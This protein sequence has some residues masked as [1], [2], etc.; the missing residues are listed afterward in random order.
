M[1]NSATVGIASTP[2]IDPINR[3]LDL[4]AYTL[5]GSVP[6]YTLHALN[7][8][9]LT[10]KIGPVTVATS[11][12]LSNGDPVNFNAQYQ[13]QRPALLNANGAIY[14]GFGAF[15]DFKLGAPRGWLLG[16]NANTL[17]PFTVNRLND[18][19]PSSP[20]GY[21]LSSIW[22]SGAGP[23]AD[24]YG[25]LYFS[26]GNSDFSGTTYDPVKNISNTVAK[27]SVD[28]TQ[29][30]SKFTPSNVAML[31]QED[32]DFGSGGV[33]LVPNRSGPVPRLAVAGGKDG[34]MGLLNR[35]VLG[36][37]LD[38][39]QIGSCWCAP[40]YFTGPDGIGR[41]VS[42]GSSGVGDNP[43][44]AAAI[45][46]WKLQT[47][48]A[49][50][51]VL[52]GAAAAV[53]SGQDGGTFT[54]VSSNGTQ[55]GTGIIWTVGRPVAAALNKTAVILYA[56]TATPNSGILVPLFAGVSGYW[57]YTGGD[58]NIVPVV[59]NGKVLVAA[60]RTL[61]IFGLHPVAAAPNSL[62]VI[63]SMQ[64]AG[65]SAPG[66][67]EVPHEITGT[68][69]EIKGSAISI[70][71]RS[72]ETVMIDATKA[73]QEQRSAIL[74]I[75]KAFSVQGTYDANGKLLATI[76]VRAKPSAGACPP[77]R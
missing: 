76:I 69:L 74:V 65:L 5:V 29:L 43:Y 22:M 53:V 35:D 46:V 57:P 40:S 72:D 42:S 52:E 45:A 34:N 44:N 60:W 75:G 61:V 20:D 2:V 39:K 31:D 47:S 33:L 55:A 7:L 36:S 62:K 32:A 8:G 28:L 64:T 58:A 15:C 12:H 38:V 27:V 6:T 63:P 73:A 77:D 13:R 49:P 17:T 21:F 24:G 14:A 50:K 54:V 11:N 23:A 51:L 48:P 70:K 18:T 26:T 30:L 59:A 68:L 9:D 67:P 4:I 10:D 3:T 66:T 37:L 71:T 56:F 1:N 19:L 16:W 41:V 25:G